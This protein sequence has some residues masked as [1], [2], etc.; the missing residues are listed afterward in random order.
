MTQKVY[1]PI[2]IHGMLPRPAYWDRFIKSIEVC[3]DGSRANIEIVN[4]K[5]TEFNA[6][7]DFKVSVYKLQIEFDSEEDRLEFLLTYGQSNDIF[8]RL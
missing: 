3:V 6:F 2:T 1:L 7:I 8:K 5:L 4:E